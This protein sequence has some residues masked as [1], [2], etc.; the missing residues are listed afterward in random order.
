MFKPGVELLDSNASL[1]EYVCFNVL[2]E[3]L[4]VTREREQ[5]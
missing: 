3:R 5:L 2:F 4:T 1:E